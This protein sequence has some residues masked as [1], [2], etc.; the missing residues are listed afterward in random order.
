MGPM[1]GVRAASFW[2]S[3]VLAPPMTSGS[4]G[5]GLRP[6]H[7]GSIRGAISTISEIGGEKAFQSAKALVQRGVRSWRRRSVMRLR[8]S[9]KTTLGATVSASSAVIQP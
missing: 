5:S 7:A 9:T 3:A 6:A 4:A 8:S 1:G 2:E